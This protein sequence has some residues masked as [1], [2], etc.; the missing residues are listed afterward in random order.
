VTVGGWHERQLLLA[1]FTHESVS[2][3]RTKNLN[4]GMYSRQHS[5]F[6][7]CR[8]VVEYLLLQNNGVGE[9]EPGGEC[10]GKLIGDSVIT[11][12]SWAVSSRA[13]S[14]PHVTDFTDVEDE[15]EEEGRRRAEPTLH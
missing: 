8:A 5:L 4:T 12:P 6:D 2:P 14:E 1:E 15:E 11:A 3:S 7:E 13:P 9:E 10:S